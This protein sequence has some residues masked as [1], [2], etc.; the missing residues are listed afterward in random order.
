M[1]ALIQLPDV[2]IPVNT[3]LNALGGAFVA[4]AS[5]SSSPP[6]GSKPKAPTRQIPLQKIDPE[7]SWTDI[8]YPSE[9]VILPP[10]FEDYDIEAVQAA[11][12]RRYA[13]QG[14]PGGQV[15]FYSG[16]TPLPARPVPHPPPNPIAADRVNAAAVPTPL[17]TAPPKIK[18]EAFLATAAPSPP[19]AQAPMPAAAAPTPLLPKVP[20]HQLQR[21]SPAPHHKK[22]ATEPDHPDCQC[23]APPCG[24]KTDIVWV[25]QTTLI[26]QPAPPPATPICYTIQQ[27]STYWQTDLGIWQTTVF[28]VLSTQWVWEQVPHVVTSAST[29]YKHKVI[30]GG[31][32]ECKKPPSDWCKDGWQN[33]IWQGD[34]KEPCWPVLPPTDD[35]WWHISWH[36]FF[37]VLHNPQMVTLI[38]IPVFLVVI[39]LLWAVK[40][41]SLLILLPLQMY[42]NLVHE[43]AHCFAGLLG[44]ARICSVG[45]DPGCGPI[46]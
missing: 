43:L 35:D 8:V 41:L 32:P 20:G 7:T 39:T 9:E 14:R 16:Y 46:R 36:P 31:G 27:T 6:S 15:V 4:H 38:M 26:D 21:R 30:P 17:P 3:T 45:T 13:R 40:R 12:A 42:T 24:T 33:G 34:G 37:P 22:C 23:E 19:L 5:S 29:T 25:H 1:P 2:A 44:G 11:E 28:P 10:P 18:V